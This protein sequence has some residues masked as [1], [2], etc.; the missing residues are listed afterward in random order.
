MLIAVT[1]AL[2]AFLIGRYTA[3]TSAA[4]PVVMVRHEGEALTLHCPTPAVVEAT[5]PSED[6]DEDDP[7]AIDAEDTATV[8]L[9]DTESKRIAELEGALGPHG[10]L[11]GKVSDAP[12][13]EP[14]A[15]VTV[16][17]S[18][19]TTELVAITDENGFYE[20]QPLPSGT[21]RVVFY[22]GDRTVEHS[23]IT[24]AARKVTPLYGTID[25]TSYVKNIPVE[26]H[27]GDVVPLDDVTF[28]SRD[29]S[30]NEYIIE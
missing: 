9:L 5:E 18:I 26:R 27:F 13:G 25:T 8:R 15:G 1:V 3:T 11:R 4:A 6:T 10:A 14:L 28:S 20:I 22:Y 2:A 24:I 7:D 17:A 12:G 19:G 23:N 30:S 29:L 21:Y 16:V